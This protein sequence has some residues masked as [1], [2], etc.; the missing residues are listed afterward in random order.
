MLAEEEV[1]VSALIFQS[2]V[3]D[4]LASFAVQIDALEPTQLKAELAMPICSATASNRV[5]RLC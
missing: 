4:C 2:G 5:F 3:K 1:D